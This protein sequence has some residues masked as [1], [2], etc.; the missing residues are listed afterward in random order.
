MNKL[1]NTQPLAQRLSESAAQLSFDIKQ[2]QQQTL[3][4][5]IYFPKLA[6]YDEHAQQTR[7]TQLATWAEQFTSRVSLHPPQALLLEIGSSLTLFGGLDVLLTLIKTSLTQQWQHVFTLSVTPTP[8]A[9]FLLASSGQTVVVKQKEALRFVLG[10]LPVN[11]LPLNELLNGKCK[12]QLLNIGVRVLRDVWRLPRSDLVRRFGPELLNYLDRTLG[13]LADPQPRYQSPEYFEESIEL[14]F[15]ILYSAFILISAR[16]LIEKLV[17]FLRQRDACIATCCFTLYN[18]SDLLTHINVSM[19]LPTR[20]I[21]HLITLFEEHLNKIKLT[22]P[23]TCVKL[24][25]TQL[26]PFTSNSAALPI[27]KDDQT[28]SNGCIKNNSKN[29]LTQSKDNI[30]RLLEQLQARLGR[31]AI[32]ELQALAD[33]RPEQAHRLGQTISSCKQST[34][35]AQKRP[36]WLLPEP[37]LITKKNDTL[38]WRGP[39]ILTTGPERIEAGWWS[40]EDVRRD[41]YVGINHRGSRLWLYRDLHPDTQKKQRWYLHGLFA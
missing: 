4:L 35:L 34:Q 37:E 26:L 13:G 7:L 12:K 19:R 39:V 24:S 30:T 21:E 36:L 9:S 23:V 32:N 29:K 38:W 1:T 16:Q 10:K 20:D 25:A 6:L 22:A 8:L 27:S 3:W 31:Q 2:A 15:E 11:V 14:P 28:V 33:H 17:T 41:Y 40:G 18:N 5:S